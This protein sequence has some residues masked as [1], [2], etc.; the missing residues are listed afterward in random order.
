MKEHERN[1]VLN[2]WQRLI[3]KIAAS[4]PG[5]WFF[6]RVLHRLD[7]LALRLSDGRWM[8]SQLTGLPLLTLTATGARSGQPRSV[9]LIGVPDGER[10]IVI[11]SNWGQEHPP[12]WYHNV[13]T[14][15]EVTVKMD[16]VSQSYWAREV[17][18]NERARAWAKA[19]ARYPG[20]RAYQTRTART[21]PVL[22]LEPKEE[23]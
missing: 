6:S 22:I 4:R 23:A 14:H 12:G 16:G 5:A 21:I 18:G 20:Y 3:L 8:L 10:L 1:E 9:P 7:R 19:I 15:P 17:E 11:A 13:R 2:R